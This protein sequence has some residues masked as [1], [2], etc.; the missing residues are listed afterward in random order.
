MNICFR[1]VFMVKASSKSKSVSAEEEIDEVDRHILSLLQED[2]RLSYN[3]VAGKAGISVGTAYNRI[4]NLEAKGLL[5]GYTAVLDSVK[6]GY[7]LT[8]IVLVQAEGG[9]LSEVEREIAKT[10]NVIAVYDVTGEF[11]AAVIAKFRDRN[12]L[13]VFIKQL[14]ASP[15]VRRTVT[16][17]ALSTVK[18]DFRVKFP[19]V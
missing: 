8:A 12:G 15:H 19:E 2:C 10:A 13:N 4:K 6:M 7:G 3:K 1:D 16:N 17:V 18:E 5:K 11:D 9:Y 14:S